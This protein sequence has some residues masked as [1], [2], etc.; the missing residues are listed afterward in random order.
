MGPAF[1]LVLAGRRAGQV[2]VPASE[3][4]RFP[5]WVR[6]QEARPIGRTAA[7]PGPSFPGRGL[8]LQGNERYD[9]ISALPIY[10]CN[11]ESSYIADRT[12]DGTAFFCPLPYF[13]LLTF[14]TQ[15]P[16]RAGL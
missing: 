15:V 9:L 6:A 12:Y 5:D 4:A 3:S 16:F 1:V 11:T 13:S 14:S 2:G 10:P 8:H 7:K